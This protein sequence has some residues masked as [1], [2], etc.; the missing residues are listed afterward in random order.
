MHHE[1]PLA[2]ISQLKR[3]FTNLGVE[4]GQTIMLHISV[5]AIG[6]IIGGPDVVLDVLLQLLTPNG[7]LMMYAAWEDRTDHWRE[8]PTER[9]SAYLAEC[10]PFDPATSRANRKW[11]IL[12][13]YLRTKPG[14]CRSDNPG[15]SMVAVGAKA[16]W[17]T[18]NHPLQYGYGPGSPLEKL[19]EIGGQVL[20]VG[21]P[22]STVTLLHYSEHM[23]NVKDKRIVKYLAP[24]LQNGQ[25]TWVEIEEFDT[26]KGIV[27]WNEDYF[28]RIIQEYL[29]SGKG[30]SGRVGA[31]QSR[32]FDAA[33][34]RRYATEWMER[35]FSAHWQSETRT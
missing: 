10:P 16:Q 29:A 8:W 22:L 9:Q 3:D 13:E 21:V 31:A 33:D 5:K 32:L 6:W 20:Q 7:T 28:A 19:C 30:N 24:I 15:A 4:P 1:L 23:A 12:V 25:L 17:L 26:S 11:S 35:T 27:N 34:L 18:N 2:T 14:A